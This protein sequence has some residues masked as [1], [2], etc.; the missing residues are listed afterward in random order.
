[1]VENEAILL[2]R[3]S[4]GADA[5]AFAELVRR[6]VQLV[7]STSW[8]VLKD[9][10]DATDVTQETF[11]ELTRHA[12]RIS[13]SLGGWLHRV[14]TQKSIDVIR[15]TAHRRNREQAYARTRPVVVQSWQEMSEHVDLA[16]EKLDESLRSVLLDHFIAGKTTARIARERG[17]SQATVSR[18]VNA[19][20]D[21]LRGILKRKGL[22]VTAAALATMLKENTAQAVSATVM[23]GLGKMAMVGTTQT[24]SAAARVGA[25][26]ALLATMAVIG[27]VSVAGYVHH[28]GSAKPAV[29]PLPAARIGAVSSASSGTSRSGMQNM[30]AAIVEPT[31]AERTR[32]GAPDPEPLGASHDRALASDPATVEEPSDPSGPKC[33]A[34]ILHFPSDQS[35]G[36]V[37][38]EDENAF[39][40]ETVGGFYSAYDDAP[41]ENFSCARGEVRIPAG[42]RVNLCIRGIGV[43]PERYRTAIDSLDP[44]DLYGLSFLALS[45]V[46]IDDH[47][48]EPIARL[49]G[50]RELRFAGVDI[51]PKALSYLAGLPHLEEFATPLGLSD[52]DMAEVTKMQSLKRLT[53]SQDR[54]TDEG[55]R[56]LGALE[57]LET[58]DLYGNPAMT[59]DG[60]A[61]LRSLHSLRSLRLGDPFSDRG[62][63]HLAALP[64]LRILQL[65]TYNVTEEGL[66]RLSQ[67][68]SL[69]QLFVPGATDR[70]IAHLATMPQ[71][72]A[73][74]IIRG[75][76]TDAALA[77]IAAMPEIEY[78]DLPDGFTDAGIRHLAKLNGLRHLRLNCNSLSAL[79]DDALAVLSRMPCL[80]ELAIGGN[81]F[82]GEGLE[83]LAHLG[84]LQSLSLMHFRPE[85]L[86]NENLVQLAKLASLRELCLGLCPNVTLSGLNALNALERLESLTVYEASQDHGGLDL[87]GL[88]NLE[89]LKISLRRQ[90]A[91]GDDA[92]TTHTC[93]DG[94]LACLSGLTKLERLSL[95]G[96]RIGNAG[97]E[98]LTS[99]ANL[100][101]LYLGGSEELTDEG[102]RHLA[103]MRRLD[104][105][106]IQNSRITEEGLAC[107]YPLKTVHILRIHSAVPMSEPAIARLRMELPHLQ[108]LELPRLPMFDLPRLQAFEPPRFERPRKPASSRLR[109]HPPVR[110]ARFPHRR[111]R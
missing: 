34:R 104:N 99:L 46:H 13:G 70:G 89:R 92:T 71:V 43:T 79:T 1:M 38:I 74:R 11:F 17:V 111:R 3:F 12:G 50:L 16:L 94:D 36:V 69:E 102:L 54:L 35:I 21:Q 109:V 47:L 62:M 57:S 100:K 5:E 42:K 95:S 24:A 73:I 75:D 2:K 27:S 58:L 56:S 83:Q 77:R 97:L 41:L 85:G 20:L 30:A 53:I 31:A 29:P 106:G 103:N 52:A 110:V 82:T 68:T 6:Y 64:S 65:T 25:V 66:R 93:D 48:I 61:G 60:L 90:D 8:R 49:T 44:N 78:L 84:N 23:G 67:S 86:A 96:F 14:A 37:Y 22:L 10:T 80:E 87:A 59:D 72:K 7:Y 51:S 63:T 39:V 26:K 55:L 107:L 45:P 28:R 76:L 81:G 101:Y 105:L 88:R 9:D 40:P 33:P 15:R 4:T 98:H 19:G 32:S 18:R 108:T 91:K